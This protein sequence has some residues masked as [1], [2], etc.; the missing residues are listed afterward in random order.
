MSIVQWPIEESIAFLL[1]YFGVPGVEDRE[2]R[3]KII[4]T[5]AHATPCRNAAAQ[6][7]ALGMTMLDLLSEAR[8]AEM[9]QSMPIRYRG[10]ANGLN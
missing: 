4:E 1:P 8:S 10:C 2:A 5:L 6:M 9:S 3:I 7:I